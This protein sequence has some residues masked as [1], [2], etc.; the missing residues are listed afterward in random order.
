[1][2]SVHLRT[3]CQPFAPNHIFSTEHLHRLRFSFRP[4]DNELCICIRRSRFVQITSP[5]NKQSYSEVQDFLPGATGT[6]AVTGRVKHI[7]VRIALL[8]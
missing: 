1:M 6:V 5:N 3:A 8:V 4:S 2:S 7:H